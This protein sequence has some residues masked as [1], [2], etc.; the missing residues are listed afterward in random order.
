MVN[1]LFQTIRLSIT[2]LADHPAIVVT[3]SLAL[4]RVIWQ[5]HSV[6][7]DLNLKQEWEDS[8]L[9]FQVD[10]RENIHEGRKF[11]IWPHNVII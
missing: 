11:K 6:E 9:L 1:C 8:R 5:K 3:V 4:N 2:E 10:P 7:V